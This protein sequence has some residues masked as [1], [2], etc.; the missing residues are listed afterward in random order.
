MRVYGKGNHFEFMMFEELLLKFFEDLRGG[1]FTQAD[2][3]R[4]VC[5]AFE[6]VGKPGAFVTQDPNV[7]ACSTCCARC[8]V[9]PPTS[10]TTTAQQSVRSIAWNS[11]F[12]RS[13]VHPLANDVRKVREVEFTAESVCMLFGHQKRRTTRRTTSRP[14]L[15]C[16]WICT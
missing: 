11:S 4:G 16:P 7:V 1:I 9:W 12:P 3:E 14:P 2:L 6:D 8:G 5:K 13:R 10:G 15:R